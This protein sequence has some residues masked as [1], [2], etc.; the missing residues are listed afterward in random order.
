M[1]KYFFMRRVLDLLAA[2]GVINRVTA[3]ALRVLAALIVLLSLV[4]FFKA[5]KVIFD[6]P[7][8]GIPGGILFQIC[9]IVAVYAVVHTFLIR[10]RDIENLPHGDLTMLPLSG[11]L[12]RLTGEAFAA[13]VSLVAIGGGL[14]VWFTG[15]SVA[16]I[17]NPVPFFFPSVG[18]SGSFMGGIEFMVGGV[19]VSLIVLIVL[20]TVSELLTVL[21]DHLRRS[22]EARPA[23][24]G[25]VRLRSGT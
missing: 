25:A 20:Y 8:H 6:L 13:Y 23:T 7:A 9:F 18:D 2:P 3:I 5:G 16:T 12:V 4:A 17:L 11:V 15:R 19:L 22:V 24:D 21:T 10:A 14:Y 1:E